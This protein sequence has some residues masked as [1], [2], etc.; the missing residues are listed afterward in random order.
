MC[1]CPGLTSACSRCRCGRT[2]RRRNCHMSR[3]SRHPRIA[4]GRSAGCRLG[5]AVMGDSAAADLC[6]SYG[7]CAW[8]RLSPGGGCRVRLAAP[9]TPRRMS[10][11]EGRRLKERTR[12]SNRS[13]STIQFSRIER[14]AA[15]FGDARRKPR[16]AYP[17]LAPIISPEGS[18]LNRLKYVDGRFAICILAEEEADRTGLWWTLAA[19]RTLVGTVM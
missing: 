10:R 17:S 2:A 5:M 15:E 13:D 11:R 6:A 18:C 19:W 7:V 1:R 8:L 14:D 9:I 3:H 4:C 16:H 12:A